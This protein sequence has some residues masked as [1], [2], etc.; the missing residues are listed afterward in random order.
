[1]LQ[2]LENAGKYSPP[3]SPVRVSAETKNGS[4][5]VSVSDR[6]PGIDSFEQSLI[7]DKFY[8]GRDHRSTIQGTG[9]GLAIAKA[10]VE[11][12]GGTINVT[13]QLGQGSVFHFTLPLRA[14]ARAQ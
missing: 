13:S 4:V 8:R 14:A 2:L 9:M 5:M 12:H 7:F 3:G 11:A 6:G 10:I 1:M